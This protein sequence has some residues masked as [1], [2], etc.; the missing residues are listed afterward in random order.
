MQHKVYTLYARISPKAS[1]ICQDEIERGRQ[2]YNAMICDLN[3]RVQADV[4]ELE[5]ICKGRRMLATLAVRWPEWSPSL[6]VQ[7]MFDT[8]STDDERKACLATALYFCIQRHATNVRAEHPASSSW[9]YTGTYHQVQADFDR[10]V[11]DKRRGTWPGTPYKTRPIR[12]Q[13]GASVG[14]HIQ[15][16]KITWQDIQS[17]VTTMFAP[18]PGATPSGRYQKFQLKVS[19]SQ[20]IVLSLKMYSRGRNQRVIPHDAIVTHALLQRAH[21]SEA[22]AGWVRV[23][24]VS[25]VDGTVNDHP[26][27]HCGKWILHIVAKL[28]EQPR[29]IDATP[30]GVS[31]GWSL[32][33]DGSLL[34]AVTSE[35]KRLCVSARAMRMARRVSEIQSEMD[36]LANAVRDYV[37]G[38]TEK[39]STVSLLD[40]IERQ[41]LIE[42]SKT[43]SDIAELCNLFARKVRR[44]K[45]IAEHLRRR[46]ANIR[47]DS[48]KKFV[49]ELS[50][51]TVYVQKLDIKSIAEDPNN[52]G[53]TS[54]WLRT[55]ACCH[56]L[57]E[58]LQH[59]GAIKVN[60]ERSGDDTAPSRQ[61]ADKI[62][63]ESQG[64]AGQKEASRR[65]LRKYRRKLSNAEVGSNTRTA[66]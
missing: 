2:Y 9:C 3:K 18:V 50:T 15:G 34:V 63:N 52:K 8:A 4:S 41:G 37:P 59:R 66:A 49:A 5:Q 64:Q 28:N 61:F 65:T 35:G 20:T 44:L 57:A 60:C 53:E 24:R 1:K 23:G 54:G 29:S 42:N 51:R 19:K 46:I 55:L 62:L 17:G 43:D 47:S 56:T 33:D 39:K 6:N 25:D 7:Q 32:Q 38:A 13:T 10:A 40:Y 21:T 30:I 11:A 36:S 27:G 45:A 58:L 48:Y 12:T 22:C 26:Y 31:L 16:G 14:A